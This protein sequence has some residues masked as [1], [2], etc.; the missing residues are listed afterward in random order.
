[1]FVF[2]KAANNAAYQATARAVVLQVWNDGCVPEGSRCTFWY[3]GKVVKGSKVFGPVDN[4]VH[5]V[6]F[7]RDTLPVH[8]EATPVGRTRVQHVDIACDGCADQFRSAKAHLAMQRLPA[9][10]G[11]VSVQT[12]I[13]P[14]KHGKGAADAAGNDPNRLVRA[15]HSAGTDVMPGAHHLAAQM[16]LRY[17]ADPYDPAGPP[18]RVSLGGQ[19]QHLI[20]FFPEDAMR[21]DV[22][23]VAKGG[24][25]AGTMKHYLFVA[26]ADAGVGLRCGHVI[27]SCDMCIARK[28]HRCLAPGLTKMGS[29]QHHVI[30]AVRDGNDLREDGLRRT[31]TQM[32]LE[33]FATH[34]KKGDT[35][36]TRV[37]RDEHAD[38]GE[39]FYL[40]RVVEPPRRCDKPGLYGGNYIGEGWYYVKLIWYHRGREDG[41]GTIWWSYASAPAEVY[42]LNIVVRGADRYLSG[43]VGSGVRGMRYDRGQRLWSLDRA[44]AEKL[45]TWCALDT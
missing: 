11:V 31:T 36:A 40:A 5:D 13:C 32:T 26:S 42:N 18:A 16:A 21:T 7:A 45:V 17:A 9:D 25:Y 10:A 19:A 38:N 3:Q 1:M 41:D 20:G 15:A 35:V 37:H 6:Y 43:A 39:M 28:H 22:V 29:M 33:Q 14:P 4:T 2:S 8:D 12:D 24:G 27:C 23:S 44:A 34:A 30:E